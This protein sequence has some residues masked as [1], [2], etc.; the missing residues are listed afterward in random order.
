MLRLYLDEDAADNA[1]RRALESA[2]FECLTVAHAGMRRR[3]DSEQVAFAAANERVLF[4]KNTG[5]FVRLHADWMAEGRAHAGIVVLAWQRMPVGV[6]LRA[7]QAL[8]ARQAQA[9]MANR[10]EFLL[11]YADRA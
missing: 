4:T 9:A 3:A 8:A 1:L 7:F 2:G 11:N 5:D 10:L 6:Q